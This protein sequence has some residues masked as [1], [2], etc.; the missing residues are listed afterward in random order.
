MMVIWPCYKPRKNVEY[1]FLG[2]TSQ[3]HSTVGQYSECVHT[4]QVARAQGVEDDVT[5]MSNLCVKILIQCNFDNDPKIIDFI[6]KN[7]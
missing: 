1:A 2:V 6:T 4:L 3:N 5:K 7:M